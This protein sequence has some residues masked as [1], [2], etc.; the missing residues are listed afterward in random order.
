MKLY[1]V[2]NSSA[3]RRVLA[4]AFHLQLPVELFELPVGDDGHPSALR[5]RQ[6]NPSGRVPVLEDG[7]YALWESNAI[8]QYLCTRKIGQALFPED[9]KTRLNIARWQFWELAHFGPSCEKPD[10]FRE[11]ARYLDRHLGSRRFIVGDSL[12]LADFSVGS[13]LAGWQASGIPLDE[14]KHLREWY[15]HLET[16]EAWKKSAPRGR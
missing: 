1:Y 3:C 15:G 5:A 13:S 6:L 8:M 9:E 2:P 7:E 11:E 14:F 16:T 10:S 12:T 4:T